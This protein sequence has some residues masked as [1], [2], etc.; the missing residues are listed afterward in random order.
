MN[1]EERVDYLVEKFK[2]DSDEYRNLEV[3]HSDQEKRWVL[4][5]LM[6]IRMPRALDEQVQQIQDEFLTEDARQKGIVT[7]DMIPT[8]R[9]QY[10]SHD[11][12]ADKVSIWQGDITRL[13]VGAIVNAANSGMLGCFVP[14]HRC[15]DNAIH[16][17]AGVQLRRECH[18]IM[19]KRR[20]QYGEF[21][22]EPTGTATLTHAYNLPCDYVIHTVGPIVSDRLTN[23]LRQDLR[24]CYESILKCALENRIKS[25][26]FCCIS[27]GE[28][29]FPNEE[30]A[31][32]AVET[33]R[34][35]LVK[36]AQNAFDRVIFDVWKEEDKIFYEY[37]IT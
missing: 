25:I 22:E 8:I 33:V 26:A 21:Y 1:Q 10:G 30:A 15:I 6:N 35:F 16:S 12:L 9:E 14:C 20:L 27:T 3:G 2:E 18:T 4:R 34:Q 28:F 29:H 37:A 31:K 7:L 13:Q 32:I 36:N 24:N 17:A 11:V 5:S 23:R 19:K